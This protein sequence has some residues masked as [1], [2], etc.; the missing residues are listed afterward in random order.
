M[1]FYARVSTRDKDQDPELQLAAM[2]EHAGARGW[3]T[4]EY[5]APRGGGCPPGSV[6]MR[7]RESWCIM[8]VA[9]AA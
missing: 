8:Q 3:E 9:K 1:A 5:I 7:G 6:G 2:Q 4:T